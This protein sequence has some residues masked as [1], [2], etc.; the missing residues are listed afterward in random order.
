MSRHHMVKRTAARKGLFTGLAGVGTAVVFAVTG[1]WLLGLIGVGAT[2][3]F[4]Y[5]WLKYRG[6]WGLRF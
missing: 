1:S 3:Y 5:K 2:G 4:G 6:K